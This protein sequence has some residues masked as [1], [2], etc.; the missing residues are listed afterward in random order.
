MFEK[1]V[2]DKLTT[3]IRPRISNKQHGFLKCRSTVTNLV[4]D[5]TKDGNQVDGVG[6]LLDVN[7]FCC[8]LTCLRIL[9][10]TTQVKHNDFLSESVHCHSGVPQGSYLRP[11]SFIDD[12]DEV[13]RIFEHV[14]ALGC[15]DDMK[16]LISINNVEDCR[17]FQTDLDSL[18]E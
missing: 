18:Q 14:S 2:C 3:T 15:T 4:I 10:D 5:D 11:W 7:N 17:R 9:K 12:A 6:F 8:V 13:L 1:I 16:L